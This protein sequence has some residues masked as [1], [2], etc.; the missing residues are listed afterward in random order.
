MIGTNGIGIKESELGRVFDKGFVGSNGR[1]GKNATG[2]GL[3]LCDQLCARL[4]IAFDAD[5]V[6][7]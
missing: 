7:Y 6:L 5:V 1:A 4:G 3:Y 2:I